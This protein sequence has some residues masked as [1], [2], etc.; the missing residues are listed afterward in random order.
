MIKMSL[1]FTLLIITNLVYSQTLEV[2]LS[3]LSAQISVGMTESN[4]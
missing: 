3:S 1:L 2:G 4:K